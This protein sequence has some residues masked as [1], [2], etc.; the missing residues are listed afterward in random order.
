MVGAT[1]LDEYRKNVE[2]DPALE[3][4]FQP[5]L[6][7]EPTVDETIQILRGLKDRYEAFHRVRILDETIVAAAEL[8]DR[9]V[10]DR[11]LPDKAIDLID[12][13][14]ARVRLGAGRRRTRIRAPWRTSCGVSCASA[15]RRPPPRTTT[16]RAPRRPDRGAPGRRRRS[17]QGPPTRGR[18]DR[19]RTSRRSSPAPPASPSRSS[20]PRS[21]SASFRL[22]EE[23]HG[24]IVG[25]DEAVSAVAEAVR[26]SRAG[27]GD[28]N[29]PVGSSPRADGVGKSELARALADALFGDETLMVRFDMSEFQERHTVSRLVGAPP[30]LRGLRGG[31]PANG[32]GPPA[33]VFRAPSTRS[34]RRTPTS[35]TSSSRS[36]TTAGSP[37]RRAARST[38]STCRDHDLESGLAPNP[39]AL[40]PRRKLRGAEAG[41]DGD[42]AEASGRSSSTGSTRSSS[43]RPCRRSS[44]ST[45]PAS[46]S[47]VSPGVSTR[48]GSRLSSRTTPPARA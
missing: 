2:A 17:A 45:S 16:G 1:T 23:L 4:R 20:P 46:S 33:P 22:E 10:R 14:S 47:T 35:S 12:Q 5:V 24:R 28:P 26:R 18:G 8:S 15:T 31:W 21:E 30:R 37:M 3:R 11:F 9:Y 27:L 38:S 34:R 40:P 29:R 32:A 25:Q 41:H 43:S 44:W 39:G 36:S 7:R 13:A 6:V 42:P 48:S 19:L